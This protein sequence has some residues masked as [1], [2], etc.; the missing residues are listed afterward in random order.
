MESEGLGLALSLFPG[1][2][3]KSLLEIF[4]AWT[5]T[6]LQMKVPPKEKCLLW[7]SKS[8]VNKGQK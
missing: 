7:K 4:G 1:A 5:L 6:N 8:E 3:E 2:G